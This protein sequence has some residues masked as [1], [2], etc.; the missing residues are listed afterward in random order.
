[1]FIGAD[2]GNNLHTI[3]DVLEDPG[4]EAR[5]LGVNALIF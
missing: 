1:M 3:L 2:G 4:R 5:I